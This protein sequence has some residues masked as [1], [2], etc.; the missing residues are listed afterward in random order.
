MASQD[1][2]IRQK[3]SVIVIGVSS[4]HANACQKISPG[5]SEK[6]LQIPMDTSIHTQM[7]CTHFKISSENRWRITL[8]M[9]VVWSNSLDLHFT[10]DIDLDC[11]ENVPKISQTPLCSINTLFLQ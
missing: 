10:Q 7:D 1:I 4:P 5:T 3:A 8:T 6:S 11:S 9:D 2:E